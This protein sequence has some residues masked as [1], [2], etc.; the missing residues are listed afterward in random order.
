[1]SSPAATALVRNPVNKPCS[2]TSGSAASTTFVLPLFQNLIPLQPLRAQ[3][4]FYFV[5]T[6]K[7][8]TNQAMSREQ[9]MSP[10]RTAGCLVLPSHPVPGSRAPATGKG[11]CKKGLKCG[12]GY[13]HLYPHPR[14]YPFLKTNTDFLSP[15]T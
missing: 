10:R 7:D 1:M 6:A 13:S 11:G 3:L 5:Q 8:T 9:N 14:S 2:V 15:E 12:Q 4:K